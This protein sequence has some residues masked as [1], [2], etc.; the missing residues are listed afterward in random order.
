MGVAEDLSLLERKLSELTVQYEHYFSGTAKTEPLALRAEVEALVRRWNGQHI[1][2]TMHKFRYH[3]LVGRY[4][5]FCGLWNRCVREIEE[6]TFKRDVFR[7]RLREQERQEREERR[8]KLFAHTEGRAGDKKEGPEPSTTGSLDDL[9]RDLLQAKA[10]C[11]HGGSDL[12]REAFDR[13]LMRQR[14]QIRK[15]YDCSEVDFTVK[16]DNGKVKLVARPVKPG[17]KNSS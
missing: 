7:V 3:T 6:G 13:M 10:D 9:Y 11:G 2:N 16:V 17:E 8:K 5:S 1:P 14:D 12:S 15:R 4:S